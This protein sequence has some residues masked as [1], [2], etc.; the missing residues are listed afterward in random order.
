MVFVTVGELGR[1]LL[2]GT[3]GGPMV[4]EILLEAPPLV[5]CSASFVA[6]IVTRS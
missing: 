2:G 3:G 4:D 5:T 6:L 1:L